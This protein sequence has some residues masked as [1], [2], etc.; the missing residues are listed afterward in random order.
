MVGNDSSLHWKMFGEI[1]KPISAEM[2]EIFKSRPKF[3]ICPNT[4]KL[5]LL[6]KN[7]N[8]A[9]FANY[10][11]SCFV[12]C[13]QS[14]INY[15]RPKFWKCW[16]KTTFGRM[17][18]TDMCCDKVLACIVTCLGTGTF[19]WQKLICVERKRCLVF[20]K[21]ST[22]YSRYVAFV[23]ICWNNRFIQM[24]GSRISHPYK[25][26]HYWNNRI[27]D[28]NYFYHEKQK[29]VAQLQ[30]AT[31]LLFSALGF[32][33]VD[34]NFSINYWIGGHFNEAVESTFVW[35]RLR[36]SVTF[37]F[38]RRLQIVLFTYLRTSLAS[39]SMTTSGMHVKTR[40]TRVNAHVQLHYLQKNI[41]ITPP[42]SSST[43]EAGGDSPT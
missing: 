2:S 17:I 6:S 21:V 9:I 41:Y 26:I 3:R 31:E 40:T 14:V 7:I 36:R 5:Q 28:R 19:A 32:L 42:P 11:L 43:H 29:V 39:L 27:I 37:A 34:L 10:Q 15:F 38:R 18:K 12:R 1:S 16:T 35:L 30:S 8:F 4:L 22:I 13:R 33:L 25:I 20:R 23:A 24:Y